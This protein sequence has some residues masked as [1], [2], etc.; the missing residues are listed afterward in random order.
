MRTPIS[1]AMPIAAGILVAAAM[2][3]LA[4]ADGPKAVETPGSGTLTMCH[5]RLVYSD[6]NSYGHGAAF[7]NSKPK[8]ESWAGAK[9]LD[10]DASADWSGGWYWWVHHY[11]KRAQTCHPPGDRTFLACHRQAG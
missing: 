1:R 2:P 5:N 11:R 9:S 6:C 7:P 8:Y 4:A 10:A 3:P